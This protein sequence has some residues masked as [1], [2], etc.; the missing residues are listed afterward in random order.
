MLAV[1][2]VGF[3]NKLPHDLVDAFRSTLEEAAY[4]DVLIHRGG[5]VIAADDD[6]L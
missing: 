2:T 6:A 5:R 3:I 4:A 1:D